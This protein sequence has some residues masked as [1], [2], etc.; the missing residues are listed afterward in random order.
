MAP[1]KFKK[2]GKVE[3]GR[4]MKNSAEG[5]SRGKAITAHNE[6][7]KIF[8]KL[9]VKER[10]QPSEELKVANKTSEVSIHETLKPALH[11]HR[12]A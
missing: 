2:T 12:L 6:T 5:K 7:R 4:V 3:N 10:K 1:A 11:S 9:H 8:I